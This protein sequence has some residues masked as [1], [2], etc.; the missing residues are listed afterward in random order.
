MTTQFI[1]QT[2]HTKTTAIEIAITKFDHKSTRPRRVKVQTHT[3]V[4]TKR[5]EHQKVTQEA[6]LQLDEEIQKEHQNA[7]YDVQLSGLRCTYRRHY[8]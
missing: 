3:I 6:L 5:H 1:G 8:E 2:K 7:Q 4:Q